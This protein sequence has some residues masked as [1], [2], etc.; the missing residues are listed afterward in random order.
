[1]SSHSGDTD[2]NELG[3]FLRARRAALDPRRAGLAPSDGLRRVAGLRREELAQLAHLS[4]DY[5]VRL[6]Q[7]RTRRISPS[8]LNA[9]ADALQLT[10]DERAYLFNLADVAPRTA[11]RPRG[12]PEIAP[13]LQ[14]LLD[15][16]HDVPAMILHRRMDILAWNRAATALLIDFGTLPPRERNYIR[17]TF[18]NEDFR[19]LFVDWP[20]AARECVAVLRR[21]AGQHRDDHDLHDLVAE[22]TSTTPPPG[23]SPSTSS[24]YPST[25]AVTNSWP[26]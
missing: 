17:L 11:P 25:P 1:M 4:F 7:G 12:R 22:L 13:P 20:T 9:L 14:H 21:E 6:G 5:I 8:V 23:N 16:M 24:N 3:Q 15:D 19:N 2:G 26:P 18:L 10:H